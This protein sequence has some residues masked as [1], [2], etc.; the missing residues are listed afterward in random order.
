MQFRTHVAIDHRVYS[1]TFM[2]IFKIWILI[3]IKIIIYIIFLIRFFTRNKN[4]NRSKKIT[5]ND[6]KNNTWIDQQIC[7]FTLVLPYNI[8]IKIILFFSLINRFYR[9]YTK[10]RRYQLYLMPGRI[11]IFNYK[12]NNTSFFKPFLRK[13]LQVTPITLPYNVLTRSWA[14]IGSHIALPTSIPT[15][16]LGDNRISSWNRI[17][18]WTNVEYLCDWKVKR[19]LEGCASRSCDRRLHAGLGIW[20]SG[21]WLQ[22]RG[23]C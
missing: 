10:N 12:N 11:Y 20:A 14:K 23:C 19:R 18:Q 5:V 7:L 17:C 6:Y 15:S 16:R 4:L 9:F 3:Q 2:R 21:V 13:N 8:A 1:N 22:L